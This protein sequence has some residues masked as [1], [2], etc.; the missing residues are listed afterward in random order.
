MKFDVS[1]DVFQSYAFFSGILVVK[2]L[3]MSFL[4]AKQRFANKVIINIGIY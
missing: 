3:V 1:D 4:T 2:M